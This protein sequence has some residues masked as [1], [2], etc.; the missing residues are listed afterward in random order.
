M[1]TDSTPPNELDQPSS[2]MDIF[3]DPDDIGT[4]E[5]RAVYDVLGDFVI[6]EPDKAIGILEETISWANYMIMR[7][8]E[9]YQPSEGTT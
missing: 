8:R 9:R 1:V 6:D 2:F 5:Y 7:I 4:A 3:D